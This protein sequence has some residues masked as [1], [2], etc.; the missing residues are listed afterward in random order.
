MLS[1]LSAQDALAPQFAAPV[2]LMAGDVP[3]GGKRAFPSPVLR[4]VNGDGKL[5]LVIGDLPGKLT[6]ALRTEQGY[7]AERP[8]LDQNGA[9]ID[10]HNW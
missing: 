5:D 10:F 9:Q 2:R 1:W 8:Y 6:V 4:D 7:A 3:I